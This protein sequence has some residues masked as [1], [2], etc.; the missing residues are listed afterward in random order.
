MN[1][2][3]IKSIGTGD[4]IFV[5]DGLKTLT[6]QVTAKLTD[7]IIGVAYSEKFVLCKDEYYR[8]TGKM[9]DWWYNQVKFP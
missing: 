3:L 7:R 9:T 4:W 8:I 6:I 2:A 5:N 1:I